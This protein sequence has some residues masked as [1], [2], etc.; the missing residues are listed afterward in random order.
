MRKVHQL[1]YRVDM[2]FWAVAVFVVGFALVINSLRSNG[3]APARAAGPA[4]APAMQQFN[5]HYTCDTD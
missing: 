5:L 1:F 3:P 2:K 4:T